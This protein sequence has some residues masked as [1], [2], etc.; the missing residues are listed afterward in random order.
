MNTIAQIMT[1]NVPKFTIS[2]PIRGGTQFANLIVSNSSSRYKIKK[3]L[4]CLSIHKGSFYFYYSQLVLYFPY[5]GVTVLI[6]PRYWKT[7][8]VPELLP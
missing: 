6:P 3:E 4:P 8:P 7:L 5:L 1:E 2:T